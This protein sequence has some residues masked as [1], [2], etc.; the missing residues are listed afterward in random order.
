MGGSSL[1]VYT[2]YFMLE[3]QSKKAQLLAPDATSNGGSFH[4]AMA[5]HIVPECLAYAVVTQWSRHGP[6]SSL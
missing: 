3:G 1:L 4:P 2:V 5:Q 6:A